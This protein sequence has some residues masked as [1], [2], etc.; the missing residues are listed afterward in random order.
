MH[1]PLIF[2]DDQLSEKREKLDKW[3]RKRWRKRWRRRKERRLEVRLGRREY[4]RL[5]KY[6]IYGQGRNQS[7]DM[8]QLSG[9]SFGQLGSL[10]A[11]SLFLLTIK[12]YSSTFVPLVVFVIH[13]LRLREREWEGTQQTKECVIDTIFARSSWINNLMKIDKANK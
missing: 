10:L 1:F 6:T 12:W 9:L 8:G 11:L 2:Y 4:H 7:V 5:D 13:T 3:E